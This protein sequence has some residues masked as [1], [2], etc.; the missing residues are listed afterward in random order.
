[1]SALLDILDELESAEP[2]TSAELHGLTF[3]DLEQTPVPTAP[4]SDPTA[5]IVQQRL[6]AGEPVRMKT[7]DI[8]E[9]YWVATD[10]QR[11]LLRATLDDKGNTTPVFSWG[12][13][14]LIQDWPVDDKR[15]VYAFKR[16]LGANVTARDRSRRPYADPTA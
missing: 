10:A 11:D 6:L 5:R 7:G 4:E 2:V 16:E 8:G 9:A 14:V 12:E 3:D 13:L 15:N 1:M